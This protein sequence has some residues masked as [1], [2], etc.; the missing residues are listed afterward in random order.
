M[1]L[2]LETLKSVLSQPSKFIRQRAE[3]NLPASTSPFPFRK[4]QQE[5]IELAL[6]NAPVVAIAGTPASGKTEIALAA[7]ATAITYQRSILVVAPFASTF[8]SYARL[9]LP[10]LQIANNQDYQQSLKDWVGQQLRDPKL[11]FLPPHWLEDAL[12]EELQTRRGRQFCLNLLRETDLTKLTEKIAQSI[13]EIFPTIHPKRQ[14]LLVYRLRQA[15]TLLEQRERLYQ[16]YTTL[17]EYAIEQIVDA[18]ISHVKAPILCLNDRLPMLGD[19]IFDLVIV[20]DSHYLNRSLLQAIALRAN[21]IVLLGELK[22]IGKPTE[23]RNLF[24]ELFQNLL[25][26]YRLQL[27]ENH[28][29]HPE[30]ARVIFPALYPFQPTPYTPTTQIYLPLKQ[31]DYRLRWY[32]VK[33]MVQIEQ[34]LQASLKDSLDRQNHKICI[35]ALSSE[36]GDYLQ[37]QLPKLSSSIISNIND[38]RGQEYDSLWIVFDQSCKQSLKPSDLQIILTR[39][40][41]SITIIG[42]WEYY[43]NSFESL[44]LSFHFVR[45]I[46]INED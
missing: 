41:I 14:E 38:L 8:S 17:S 18:S 12:F 35:Y 3:L 13:A 7:I 24:N 31:G 32:D 28:R 45:D 5:A 9:P 23:N 16:D 29:L 34:T 46:S 15:Q 44:F 39:A 11:D 4:K 30:L 42:D 25:S 40:K 33:N 36:L 10:P 1:T 21:K 22:E 2:P 20:E 37:Q 27:N 19:R 43:Q 6:S 26:A